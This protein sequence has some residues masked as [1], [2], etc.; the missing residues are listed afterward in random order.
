[1][2]QRSLTLTALTGLP[3]IMPGMDLARLLLESALRVHAGFE[4]GDVLLVGQKIISKSEG[5]FVDLAGVRPGARAVELAAKCLKDPR[6]V[7]LVLRESTE[8]VRCAP[9][10]LIVRHRLGFVVA[11]AGIDQS[12]VPGEDIALLLPVDPDDSAMRLRAGLAAAGGPQARGPAPAIIITDS[13]GRP[14]RQGVLGTAI[15]S[16]GLVALKD[17]RGQPDRDGRL[18]QVT[19]VAIADALAAAACLVMGE[20]AEGTP[21]VLARGLPGHLCG[22]QRASA[23]VRPVSEDLFR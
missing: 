2:G 7:E 18:L 15:G 8:V 20:A 12:N 3:E 4:A 5:R 23:L 14:F 6:L 19:Q 22:S 16:A 1:M 13:F 11:N 17:L 9:N 21:A 10:V